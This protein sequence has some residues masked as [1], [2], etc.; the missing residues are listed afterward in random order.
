MGMIETIAGIRYFLLWASSQYHL[1]ASIMATYGHH[2]VSCGHLDSP[3][4]HLNTSTIGTL[5]MDSAGILIGGSKTP[6]R[7]VEEGYA[8]IIEGQVSA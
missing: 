8:G 3:C 6:I 2:G 7:E 1:R 4:G 5:N